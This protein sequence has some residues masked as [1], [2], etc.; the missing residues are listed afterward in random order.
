[1]G[2]AFSTGWHSYWEPE[3]WPKP[4]MPVCF[5]PMYGFPDG[6]Q[7][8]EMKTTNE[9]MDKYRLR[10]DERDYCAHILIDYY[11]CQ[12]E[13]WPSASIYCGHLKHHWEQ[14]QKDDQVLRMKE[15]ERERRL[16]AK[17]RRLQERQSK[18]SVEE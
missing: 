12:T 1:M 18:E 10:L 2:Q 7:K 17:E 15:F 6:R 8:R 11:K 13:N 14:C 5:D 4:H 3:K 16:L 9:E